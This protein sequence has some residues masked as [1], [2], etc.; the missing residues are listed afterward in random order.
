[1]L[2]FILILSFVIFNINLIF[3]QN[4]YFDNNTIRYDNHIYLSSIK[5]IQAFRKGF[6]LSYPFAELN[7][8][9]TLQFCFDDL[10]D[11][12]KNYNYTFIHCNSNWQPSGLSENE[13]LDGFYENPVSDYKHS[14]NTFCNYYHYNIT[15]PNENIKLKISGNYILLV[16]E[17]DKDLPVITLRFYVV[18]TK[19]QVE[20]VVK[21][22]TNIDL[23]KSHQ[24]IDFTLKNS[25]NCINP[26]N[27]II[28]YIK[29]NDRT[30][31]QINNLKPSFVKDNE[32]IYNY[33][34]GNVF[35]GGNEFRSFDAKSY[36]YQSEHIQKIAYESP[37][38]HV[39]LYYDEKQTFKLYKQLQ[40]ING[41]YLIKNS[42]ANESEIDADYFN[43]TFTLPYEA[44]LTEGNLY[45]LGAFSNWQFTKDN[46]LNYNYKTKCY[47]AT[48]LLKQGFYNYQYA[49]LRD[50]VN[51][52]DVSFIEGNHYQ[53]ENDY[54]IF[55]YWRDI[56]SKYDRLTGLKVINSIYQK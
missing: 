29:Q 33:E 42:L 31:N 20:A 2:K 50:S 5:T 53:T 16:Y 30:D 12:A 22:A 14:F 34:D 25:F 54:L 46:M 43:V 38:Y 35:A 4:D 19:T 26:F 56:T 41:K 6:E 27:D 40:D 49:F 13:Y 21:Q 17:N 18:E 36:K 24:E 51:E 28:V 44:P 15:L 11:E 52:S 55:V 32:L 10:T 45:V 8:N 1:M 9:D 39:Y 7:S 23:M 37:F 48:I 3:S 47:E